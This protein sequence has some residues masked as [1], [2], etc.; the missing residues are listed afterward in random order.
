MLRGRQLLHLQ[1]QCSATSAQGACIAVQQI[2][3]QEPQCS[4]SRVLALAAKE[5]NG[6]R[7]I[8]APSTGRQGWCEWITLQGGVIL[9]NVVW[10][11]LGSRSLQVR[12][13]ALHGGQVGALRSQL[14][15]SNKQ[16]HRSWHLCM[17]STR[18]V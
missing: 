14:Q 8:S 17:D 15:S 1:A 7:V 3:L 12:L 4:I 10:Q 18:A 2:S 11:R 6:R 13:Q 9:K 16:G 5:R